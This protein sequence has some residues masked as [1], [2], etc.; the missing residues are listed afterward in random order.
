MDKYPGSRSLMLRKSRRSLTQTAMVTYEQRVLPRGWLDNI[1]HFNVTDQQYE[2]PNGSILAVGGLDDAQKIMSS[3]WDMIYPQ[4]ATELTEGD[5]E[6]LTT[7]LRWHSMPYQ[8][9][10]GD[11]NPNKPTHWLK[12][13]CDKG[14]TL[15]L[16][17]RHKD[18]PT[19]T[20]ED[21]DALDNLTGVRRKRLR[22]GQWAAAEGMVYE[23]WDTSLHVIDAFEIP[24]LWRRY[25][26]IDWGFRNPFVWQA[27]AQSH[28]GDLYCYHE[29]FMTGRLVEDLARQVVEVTAGEPRPIGVICDHDAEDRATFA[30]HA[31]VDTIPASKAIN[32]GIQ[33]VQA[34]LKSDKR[35]RPGVRYFRDCLV[36]RDPHLDATK[37]PAS[38]IEEYDGYV[39]DESNGKKEKEVPVDKDNHGMDCSRYMVM[40]VDGGDNLEALDDATVA[41]L[42]GYRGY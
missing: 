31:Q 27:W 20:K 15:M 9:L 11:C 3:E 10:L 29:I 33:A 39:W 7:R 38:T 26:A 24:P 1:I 36:E 5:W 2:Y 32:L 12:K 8:Q 22:D 25:W 28:D 23:M 42:S 40:H 6:D 18:N 13:R 19:H 34:R 35:G 14:K 30:R 37:A 17:S 4:E 21:Q 41:A 16:E